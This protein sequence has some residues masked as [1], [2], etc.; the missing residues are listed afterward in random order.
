MEEAKKMMVE[1]KKQDLWRNGGV[2]GDQAVFSIFNRPC[3]NDH[4]VLAWHYL[5][6]IYDTL[7]YLTLSDWDLNAIDTPDQVHFY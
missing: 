2:V 3:R 4:D 5:L 7:R 1:Q 6:F